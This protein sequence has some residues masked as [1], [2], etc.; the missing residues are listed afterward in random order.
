[1]LAKLLAVIN[2]LL[3]TVFKAF[4]KVVWTIVLAVVVA[5]ATTGII[6]IFAYAA[7]RQ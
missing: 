3:N 1:M 7:L 2:V 4:K 6:I 5:S